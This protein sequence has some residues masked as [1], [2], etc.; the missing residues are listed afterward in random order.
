MRN[1][2]AFH[3]PRAGL[4]IPATPEAVE[5]EPWQLEELKADSRVVIESGE[6]PAPA[7]A[8]KPEPKPAPKPVA[9][10]EKVPEQKKK[11]STEDKPKRRRRK[12]S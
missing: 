7:P 4:K 6:A 9:Q 5:C 1:G 2:F 3:H 12:S 11:T 8:P 10:V